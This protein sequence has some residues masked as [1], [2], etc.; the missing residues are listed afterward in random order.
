M[1]YPM[2]YIELFSGCGGLSLGLESLG[3]ELVFAN[4]LSPMASETY[5]INLLNEDLQELATNGFSAT[6][7]RWIS[8]Q[9]SHYHLS[10]RLRENPLNFPAWSPENNELGSC[11]SD[12]QG[13]LLVGSIVELNKYFDFNNSIAKE[14]RGRDIDLISGGPPCQ[15]FSM[16]GLRQHENKRNTLPM[17]FV[18][19]V[20]TTRP[21]IALLENVSGILRAFSLP[22]GKHYAWFEVAKAFASK[23]YY[24]LCLHVNAKYCGAAQ[25]RPRFI[26]IALREDIF[27]KFKE[28]TKETVILNVLSKIENF[29]ALEREGCLTKPMIDLTYYDI[30]KDSQYFETALLSPLYQYK[31]ENSWFSVADAIDDLNESSSI[32][33]SDY[34]K[35]LNTTF[36]S[37]FNSPLTEKGITNHAFRSNSPRIKMRF[38]LYQN[39]SDASSETKK[40][41]QEF[42][43]NPEQATLKETSVD[44]LLTHSYLANDAISYTKFNNPSALVDYL[45]QLRTKKHTQRALLRNK[46]APAAL[47][48]PDD[49]CHYDP[50]QQRTLS[51]REMARF[52]SFPDTFVFRSKVT[53]GGKMRRFEVPQ[54]TQVGNAVPPLLGRALGEVVSNIL[55]NT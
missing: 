26:L 2:K 25:N 6:K 4:E 47:S 21:K 35:L 46:P 38:K 39:L 54:Y 23:G 52:Q 32:N 9:H 53:T 11:L 50:Q 5:A 22:T 10:A 37:S 48:I 17:D 16:A 13:K 15:S 19:L 34:P 43:K 28:R 55:H 27:F 33:R 41:V 20:N 24:P 36:K 44:F 1:N 14:L 18:N 30:A 29:L 45:G 7:V 12:I 42:L 49:A 31:T 8:S 40:D 51:V 3:Y